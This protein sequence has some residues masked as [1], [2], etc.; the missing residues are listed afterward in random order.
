MKVTHSATSLAK[1]EDVIIHRISHHGIKLRNL[2]ILSIFLGGMSAN[3]LDKDKTRRDLI[4]I[5]QNIG[6]ANL[7]CDYKY[8]ALI[9]APEF[10]FTGPDGSVTTR[11]QDLAG[12]ASC[13]KSTSKYEVDEANVWLDGHVAVVT[14]RVTIRKA[15]PNASVSRSRFTDVFVHRDHRWQLVAGHSSHIRQAGTVALNR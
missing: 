15:D 6:K 4:E 12:E 7:N 1:G 11:D 13:K 5:E 2:L 3:A 10:V 9:E 14:G 8:F